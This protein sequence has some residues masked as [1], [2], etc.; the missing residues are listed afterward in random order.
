MS[1]EDLP[2][3]H[4][5]LASS[6]QQLQISLSS[7]AEGLTCFVEAE[8]ILFFLYIFHVAQGPGFSSHHSIQAPRELEWWEKEEEATH[9]GRHLHSREQGSA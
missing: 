1:H 7:L 9:G 3:A 6:L 5:L 8:T 2:A 4:E